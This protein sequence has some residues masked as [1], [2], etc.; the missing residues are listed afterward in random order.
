MDVRFGS[1]A[2]EDCYRNHTL[3]RSAWGEKI[4]TRYVQR[5]N[6]LYAARSAADLFTLKALKLHPLK[7]KRKG[8]HALRLDVDW[9]MVVR[10]EGE[11]WTVVR[12]EEVS[13]HYGD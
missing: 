11:R 7:G 4:A 3:G 5:V 8:Q 12:V 9:R 13:K 2:L 6:Q 10:F 1:R